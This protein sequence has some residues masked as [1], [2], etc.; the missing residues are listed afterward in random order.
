MQETSG[1]PSHHIR[2]WKIQHT[3][4]SQGLNGMASTKALMAWPHPKLSSVD[5]TLVPV[6]STPCCEWGL[7]HPMGIWV[8]QPCRV[9]LKYRALA[10]SAFRSSSF[11]LLLSWGTDHTLHIICP[12]LKRLAID[13]PFA[14]GS[15][16][17]QQGRIMTQTFVSAFVEKHP[18][19]V[20]SERCVLGDGGSSNERK[21]KKGRTISFDQHQL[22]IFSAHFLYMKGRVGKK[23]KAWMQEE[24]KAERGKKRSKK[25]R[26]RKKML[27][28]M[29]RHSS[30]PLPRSI[31]KHKSK[32]T[33][34]SLS[35]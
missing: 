22:D 12:A 7:E 19:P 21:C 11:T 9:L 26:K 24:K 31:L 14:G 18:F 35:N 3:I 2:V 23:K 25:G 17:C 1:C 4:C 5:F 8:A 16:E 32:K 13:A 34:G 10:G 6:K 15:S 33:A 28:V 20:H 27:L 29:L 30:L